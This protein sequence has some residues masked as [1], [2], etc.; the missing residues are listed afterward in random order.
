MWDFGTNTAA[1][2]ESSLEELYGIS[3]VSG[4]GS[5]LR[6]SPAD[7]RDEYGNLKW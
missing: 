2:M 6:Y 5:S 1:I 7:N 3:G 4:V